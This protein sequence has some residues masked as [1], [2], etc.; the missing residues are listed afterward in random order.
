MIDHKQEH[1][2]KLQDGTGFIIEVSLDEI[3]DSPGFTVIQSKH[4]G[5]IMASSLWM[6]DFNDSTF[7]VKTDAL[8]DEYSRKQKRKDYGVVLGD[9]V[10]CQLRLALLAIDPS[11]S[12]HANQRANT[13][14]H[15]SSLQDNISQGN[16]IS[17]Y[18]DVN[19]LTTEMG[20]TAEQ[21]LLFRRLI[22]E[23]LVSED[24]VYED[25]MKDVLE[26]GGNMVEG[27]Q[28]NELTG[29]SLDS[30]FFIIE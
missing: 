28:Y 5:A 30:Q 27:A 13:Y 4:L 24:G 6:Y 25:A 12:A 7:V 10:A 21:I 1:N 17:A 22:S 23:Y 15:F 14:V 2:I 9:I 11:L 18:E 19:T 29:K 8:R 16:F 3:A 26:D 20:L